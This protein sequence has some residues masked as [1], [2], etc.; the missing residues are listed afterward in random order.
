MVGQRQLET[1][2]RNLPAGW[3]HLFGWAPGRS[4]RTRCLLCGRTGY[5]GLTDPTPWQLACIGGHPARCTTCSRPFVDN[6]ALSGHQRCTLHHDCCHGHTTVPA[7]KN[8]FA[9]KAAA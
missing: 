3:R 9:R 4:A 2:R 8:P 1:V 6:T 5:G 7:W